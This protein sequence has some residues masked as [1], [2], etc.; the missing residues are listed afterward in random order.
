MTQSAVTKVL[1][2]NQD[3]QYLAGTARQWEFTEDRSRA[4]VF[5]FAQ[6]H[7]AE[8]IALVR[9]AHGMVWIA[10]KLDPRE[11]YEFCD[12]CGTRSLPMHT[13]FDGIQFLCRDCKDGGTGPV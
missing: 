8:Q 4:K 5:D 6:D 11:A 3:G 7:V 13:Y 10:V 9:K 12:R 2:V 1:I